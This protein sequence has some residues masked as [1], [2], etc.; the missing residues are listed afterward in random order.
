M[1]KI[2]HPDIQTFV[3]SFAE[4]SVYLMCG[5]NDNK[6]WQIILLFIVA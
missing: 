1:Q 4:M 6:Q 5:R 3:Q 2:A